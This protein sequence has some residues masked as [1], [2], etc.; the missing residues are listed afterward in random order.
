MQKSHW[1][2][3]WWEKYKFHASR[4]LR[5]AVVEFNTSLVTS[6]ITGLLL[7]SFRIWKISIASENGYKRISGICGTHERKMHIRESRRHKQDGSNTS[8]DTV[9]M[10]INIVRRYQSSS[11]LLQTGSITNKVRGSKML[12]NEYFAWFS[13]NASLFH[14]LHS[15]GKRIF[16]V[17]LMCERGSRSHQ[18]LLW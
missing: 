17:E 3:C 13:L 1:Y 7:L 4:I 2:D 15:K 12:R 10:T 9:I 18:D 16:K 6:Y 5:K 11:H 14:S 8:D